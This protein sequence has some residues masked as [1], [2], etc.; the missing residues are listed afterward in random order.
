ML[1][2]S[3]YFTFDMEASSMTQDLEESYD[4]VIASNIGLPEYFSKL[5]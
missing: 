1:Q 3:Q 4:L 2:R 5:S